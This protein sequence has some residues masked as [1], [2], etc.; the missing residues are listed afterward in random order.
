MSAGTTTIPPAKIPVAPPEDKQVC[1]FEKC[2]QEWHS[3]PEFDSVC[4]TASRLQLD[5]RTVMTP[6]L[7]SPGCRA[8]RESLVGVDSCKEKAVP[9]DGQETEQQDPAA[10]KLSLYGPLENAACRKGLRCGHAHQWAEFCIH[11]FHR[12]G[13]KK[14]VGRNRRLAGASE[15]WHLAIPGQLTPEVE[16]ADTRFAGLTC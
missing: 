1:R 4:Y 5:N 9:I 7:V 3:R 14:L 6:A 16:A 15:K 8:L 10:E 13:G 12:K 11:T 2:I